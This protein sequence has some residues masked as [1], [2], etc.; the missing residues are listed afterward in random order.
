MIYLHVLLANMIVL[1]KVHAVKLGPL[2]LKTAIIDLLTVSLNA[3]T[4]NAGLHDMKLFHMSLTLAGFI[5]IDT[6][7]DSHI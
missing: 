5:K 3:I 1:L 7:L 6:K 2:I 4:S